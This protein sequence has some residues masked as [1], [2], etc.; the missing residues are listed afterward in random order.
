MFAIICNWLVF[1]LKL[2]KIFEN[3]IEEK[4]FEEI[5]KFVGREFN[6]QEF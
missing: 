3:G 2:K 4:S 1:V 6:S 5:K